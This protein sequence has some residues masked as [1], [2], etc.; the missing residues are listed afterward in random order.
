M[1]ALNHPPALWLGAAAASLA[2]LLG[3][4]TV[5]R[6][7]APAPA[8]AAAA[9]SVPQQWLK[10]AAHLDAKAVD[11]AVLLPALRA[12][13]DGAGARY[14][15]RAQGAESAWT[16]V[17]ELDGTIL[18]ADPDPVA[19]MLD[20]DIDADGRADLQVLRGPLLLGTSLRDALPFVS[21]GAFDNQIG[22]AEYAIALNDHAYA[23]LAPQ[24][25]AAAPGQKLRLLG[26]F[27]HDPRHALPLL[28]PVRIERSGQ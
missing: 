18:A 11:A 6:K 21:Y 27:S 2:F 10:I 5:V 14:G 13:P 1:P 23:A 25:R 22:F 16:F 7:D 19:P 17:T 26:T 9:P 4:A 15:Y 20:V 8:A 12:D 24:L 3:S 28:M